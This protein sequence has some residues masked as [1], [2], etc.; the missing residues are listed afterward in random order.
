VISVANFTGQSD[1]KDSMG[2]RQ[3]RRGTF[4]RSQK[5]NWQLACCGETIEL[6]SIGALD[7][8]RHRCPKC[9]T[10]AVCYRVGSE[11]WEGWTKTTKTLPG[12]EK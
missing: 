12:V 4:I 1:L 11:L 6:H 8:I 7:K 9:K 3:Q 5:D 2:N 10:Q